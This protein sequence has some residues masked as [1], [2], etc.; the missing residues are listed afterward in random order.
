MVVERRREEDGGNRREENKN[1]RGEG[2]D[3][4]GR[5]RKMERIKGRKYGKEV[6]EEGN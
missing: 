5:S 6:E 2:G 3:A 4:G 1:V